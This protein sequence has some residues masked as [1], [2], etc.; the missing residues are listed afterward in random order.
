MNGRSSDPE[1]DR[2]LIDR[3]PHKPP[4]LFVDTVFSIVPGREAI[5]GNIFAEDDY[6]FRGHFP[7]NPMVPGFILAEALA[8]T[9]GLAISEK[10]VESGFLA[11]ADR[12]RFRGVAKPGERITLKATV[13]HRLGR[14]YRFRVEA[15]SSA[16]VLVEGE[17]TLSIQ[18]R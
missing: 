7:G 18:P 14:V 12:L 11:A 15:A 10:T 13:A 9:A 5:A 16:G 4:F 8:Q 2:V 3:L 17:I 6:F 1:N